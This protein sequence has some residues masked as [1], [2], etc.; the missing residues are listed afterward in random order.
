MVAAA[1]ASRAAGVRAEGEAET[2]PLPELPVP[3]EPP[4]SELERQMLDLV[5]GSRTQR[6][7]APLQ[8]D[9]TMI[10]VARAH[11]YDMMRTGRISHTGSDG[12]SPV[13]RLR[14]AGVQ[15]RYGSENIWTYWGN[16]PHEGPPT[17][18]AAMMA[19][20]YSPGVWN[21]IGNIL[22]P[23]YKRIGVGIAISPTGVQYLAENFTD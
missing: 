13:Q 11:A 18:H 22:Y 20:P 2:V 6:K 19:E 15:F 4:M 21:H 12:S 5:N 1:L 17:M 7:V 8:W 10:E 3:D 14:R 16:V 23:G 9:A